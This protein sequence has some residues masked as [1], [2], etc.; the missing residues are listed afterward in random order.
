[1][2]RRLRSL[3]ALALLASACGGGDAADAEKSEDEKS[4]DTPSAASVAPT[5]RIIEISM[6]T[7]ERG[8]YF[9]PAIFEAKQG[10][11]LRFKLV[12]GVHN[13]HFLA[14]S[15]PSA[16]GLPPMT[17]FLQLPGQTVDVPLNFGEGN[18]YFQCDP[19]AML[20]MIGRVKVDD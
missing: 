1:M 15:N 18:F 14:D 6:H 12:T 17:A 9:E 4:D 5:G 16:K 8:N 11:V 3:L 10:D 13:V 7:N 20:G 19:H 2:T